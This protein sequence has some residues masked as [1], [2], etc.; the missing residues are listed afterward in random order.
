MQ[1]VTRATS[2]AKHVIYIPLVNQTVRQDGAGC[3]IAN[4]LEPIATPFRCK[5]KISLKHKE[6]MSKESSQERK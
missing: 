3:T 4:I 1:A 5:K 2:E 6:I